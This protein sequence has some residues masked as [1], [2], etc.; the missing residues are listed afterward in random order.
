M[1]PRATPFPVLIALGSSAAYGYSVLIIIL[2]MINEQYHGMG[3]FAL[4]LRCCAVNGM[5]C[6]H[7]LVSVIFSAFF[8]TSAMLISIVLFGR[9]V[10]VSFVYAYHTK[11]FC[12]LV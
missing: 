2:S 7:L 11:S 3:A 12:D 10:L 4:L 9:C 6:L 1:L 5:D 8:E